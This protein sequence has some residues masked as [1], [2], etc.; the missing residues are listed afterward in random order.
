[1]FSSADKETGE[2]SGNVWFTADD[3]GADEMIGEET[4]DV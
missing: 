2:E 1:M 4:G 3:D